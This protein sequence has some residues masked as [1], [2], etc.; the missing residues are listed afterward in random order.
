MCSNRSEQA[1]NKKHEAGR[2]NRMKEEEQDRIGYGVCISRRGI[3]RIVLYDYFP[4]F[5][6]VQNPDYSTNLP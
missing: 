2:N 5:N 6:C 4:R 3:C 1:R